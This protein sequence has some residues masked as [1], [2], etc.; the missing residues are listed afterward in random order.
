MPVTVTVSIET[1]ITVCDCFTLHLEY[2]HRTQRHSA[3]TRVLA[4]L[5]RSLQR[6]FRLDRTPRTH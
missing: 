3:P 1:T 4:L 6:A 5:P 2:S